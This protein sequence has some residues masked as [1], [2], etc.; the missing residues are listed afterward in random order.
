MRAARA[1]EV[2]KPQALALE[3]RGRAGLEYRVVRSPPANPLDVNAVLDVG[4]AVI[5]GAVEQLLQAPHQRLDARLEQSRLNVGQ[6]LPH[7]EQG[8]DLG[9]IEPE[10]GELELRP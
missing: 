5:G 3:Q 9:R 2:R 10:A 8:V 7:G 1:V 4:Q 6:Q